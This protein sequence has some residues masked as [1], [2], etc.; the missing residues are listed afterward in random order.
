[1]REGFGPG[2]AHVPGDGNRGPSVRA[3][4]ILAVSALALVATSPSAPSLENRA[5]GEVRGGE[6]TERELR[7]HVD[8]AGGGARRGAIA[9][10]FQAASGLQSSYTRDATLA[11]V[12][13]SD[14]DGPF[15]PS[16]TF[17]VERCVTGCD[18]TYRIRIFTA[19]DLLP[20]SVIRYEVNV[21]LEYDFGFGSRDPALL[22]VDLD[23]QTT[24]PVAPLWS[25]LAGVLA[26][27]GGIAAGPIVHRKLGPGWRRSPALA[28]VAWPVGLIG[29]MVIT[30]ESLGSRLGLAPWPDPWSIFLHGTLGWG[31]WRGIRRWPVDGGWLLGR[32]ATATVG[33][34]GLWLAWWLTLDAIVQPIV[35]AI[36]FVL[37]GGLGGIVIGQAWRTNEQ[38]TKDRPWAALAV[39]SHGIVIAGFAFLAEQSLYD[40]PSSPVGSLLMLIPTA[41]V[42]WAFRHWL[43][44]LRGPLIIFDIT[45][46]FVG[47]LGLLL[48]SSTFVGSSPGQFEMDDAAVLVAITAAVVA[49]VTSFHKMGPHPGADSAGTPDVDAVGPIAPVSPPTPVAD[50]PPT[51]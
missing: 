1:M 12:S 15:P 17:P 45:I 19:P 14:A 33:L 18:L 13:A 38:A 25:L 2:I 32:A 28:L 51:T 16:T 23:G 11:L 49:A 9:L 26:L 7:I 34:G 10:G 27:V 21:Q 40:S 44:G 42:A 29:W 4:A 48:W 36:P 8:P 35:L 3:L 43:R 39:I 30:D 46:A 24:G 50:D 41:L 5:I 20:G 37:L 31:V 6:S 47:L 22:R